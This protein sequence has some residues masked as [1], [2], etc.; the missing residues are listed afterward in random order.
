M[1]KLTILKEKI[2]SLKRKRNNAIRKFILEKA[3]Y[4]I[5]LLF[6]FLGFLTLAYALRILRLDW[7]TPPIGMLVT[8][9][10]NLIYIIIIQVNIR[11]IDKKLADKKN[12]LSENNFSQI[13]C[14]LFK[15]LDVEKIVFIKISENPR[16]IQVDKGVF[17]N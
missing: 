14:K 11:K 16:F 10:L 8:I 12:L 17:M 9:M 1:M 5:A 7:Y 6:V 13:T 4:N 3:N 15:K 2:V